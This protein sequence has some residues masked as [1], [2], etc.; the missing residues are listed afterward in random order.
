MAADASVRSFSNDTNNNTRLP[1]NFA[2]FFDCRRC[3]PSTA[4]C[5]GANLCATDFS[6]GNSL[7]WPAS[8]TPR[9]RS[10]TD[11]RCHGAEA[12]PAYGTKERWLF[13]AKAPWCCGASELRLRGTQVPKLFGADDPRS[14]GAEVLKSRS[15]SVPRCFRSPAPR[16]H[17]ARVPRLSGPSVLRLSGA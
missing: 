3:A 7:G 13:G 5:I 2:R 15:S 17:G 6:T 10:S 11:R 16:S 4:E 9:N 14:H 1:P 12:L 8:L